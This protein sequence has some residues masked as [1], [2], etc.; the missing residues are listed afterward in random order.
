M[1]TIQELVQAEQ[2][3]QPEVSNT[4]VNESGSI[5]QNVSN[6]T[7]VAQEN[8]QTQE[9]NVA[10]FVMPSFD[11]E[12]ENTENQTQTQQQEAKPL[13]LD[14]IDKNELLKAAGLDEYDIEFINYRKSGGDP[15]KYI[16]AK[17]S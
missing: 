17:I 2:K 15:L 12:T 4:E 10:S 8:N 9:E 7:T 1:P 13:S 16:E 11:E 14:K 5:E 3:T 6:E